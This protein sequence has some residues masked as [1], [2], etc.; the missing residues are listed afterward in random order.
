MLS[1]ELF[2]N[3]ITQLLVNQLTYQINS[4]K[5]IDILLVKSFIGPFIL[6]FF[7]SLF[8][9]VMQFLW[10]Y[11]D[12]LVGKGLDLSIIAE[13]LF[14]TSA[15]LVPMALPLAILLASIMVFGNLGEHFELVALKSSG[16]SL[17]RIM[18]SLIITSILLAIVAFWFSNYVLPKA[19]LKYG[20]LLYDIRNKQPAFDIEEGIF[21]NGIKG[22]SIKV[23]SKEEDNRT[24][25]DVIIYDHTKGRGNVNVLI[26]EKAEMF[27]SENAAALTFKL[28]NGRQYEEVKKY[29]REIKNDKYEHNYTSFKTYVKNF[30]MSGFAMKTT[31][32][33]LFKKNHQM[34][35]VWQLQHFIDSITLDKNKKQY[36]LA[37]QSK[38]YLP[39]TE[40]YEKLIEEKTKSTYKKPKIET[41][42][43]TG[44]QLAKTTSTKNKT[45]Q[46]SPI[47]LNDSIKAPTV[48]INKKLTATNKSKQKPKIETNKV[49]FTGVS[50]LMSSFPARLRAK[51][52]KRAINYARNIKGYVNVSSN[53]I[54]IRTASVKRYKIAWHTK[55][56]LSFACIVLFFIGAPL[57]AITK[58]GGL[59]MP[60]ILSIVFFVIYHLLNTFGK[61][62]AQDL[63]LT[64]LQGIWLSSLVLGIVGICLTYFALNDKKL[65]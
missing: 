12:D 36:L 60:M 4:M 62:F 54:K 35:N 17:I 49:D 40:T 13:L 23:A 7:I 34:L 63:I 28:Y 61:K 37:S 46:K 16:I 39:F 31:K 45:K 5:K 47:K 1:C 41:D 53:E 48:E 57:G 26:A 44:K 64:P 22:Y 29:A 30:D 43:I 38:G 19:N 52:A 32:E 10:K 3:N 24:L 21:Y 25:N 58:K 50:D 14:Y 9:F 42:L 59:G 27:S 55:F 2:D 33:A 6:T 11:I 20:V 65:F 51:I 8:V 56:T 15:S 18:K